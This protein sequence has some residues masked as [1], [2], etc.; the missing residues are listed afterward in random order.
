MSPSTADGRYRFQNYVVGAAN[1]LAVSAARAVAQSPGA[2]YNPL[3]IYSNSGLGKTHLLLA[4]AQ[5]A[6]ELA[7]TLRT[8]YVALGEM[9]DEL[10]GAVA[11]GRVAE[12]RE[13]FRDVDMLLLDDV[14]F[15]AGRRE[16]QTE[17]LRM[18]DVLRRGGR[19]LVLASD[20]PPAEIS[21]LDEHLLTRF[22]GGLIV[23]IDK[24]DYETRVAILRRKCDEFGINFVAGVTEAVARIGHGNV[25]ELEGALT[26]LMAFQQLGEGQVVPATVPKILGGRYTPAPGMAAIPDE[27]SS[28]VSDLAAFVSQQVDE[29]TQRLADAVAM[30][31]EAGYVTDLLEGTPRGQVEEAITEFEA[32][33]K[34]LQELEAAGVDADPS[35]AGAEAFR[36]PSRI[37]EAENLV[38]RAEAVSEPPPG[39]V[40]VFTRERYEIAPCNQFAV[41]AGEAVVREPG[42]RYNPLVIHGE[43]GVG[44]SH[45]LHAIG[46]GLARVPGTRVACAKAQL[47]VDELIA[48]LEDGTVE[49]WRARWRDV[50]ALLLDDAQVIAG[51]EAAQVELFNLFNTLHTAGKQIVL[52]FDCSPQ[53]LETLDDRLR[54]RFAG[55]LVVEIRVPDSTLRQRLYRALLQ[56]LGHVVPTDVL[57]YLAR[58]ESDDVREIIVTA[59]LLAREAQEKDSPIT[60]GFARRL[61]DDAPMTPARSA[62]PIRSRTAAPGAARPAATPAVNTTPVTPDAAVRTPF[63]IT[64]GIKDVDTFF[65]DRD[66]TIWDWPELGGR[67]IEEMR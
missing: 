21:E 36:D 57:S 33:V 51:T 61:L 12:F 26:R 50:D 64:P 28:F 37:S 13:R 25:R 2:A 59:D 67:A 43:A 27:F 4:T 60:L 15:L 1:R 63:V 22:S 42:L 11:A 54:S 66:K 7:P 31:S 56:R 8:T 30:W 16:T 38:S 58:R 48:A 65:L 24:P 29:S 46:N 45:L 40:E 18:F 34:R 41:H 62:T 10:H 23:D 20:R 49:R 17:L 53:Q 44:K 39:P 19:Q 32:A 14:Q 3:F 55:G 35:L 5:L 9:V 47:F 52:A 6:T